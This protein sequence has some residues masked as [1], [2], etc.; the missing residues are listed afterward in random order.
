MEAASRVVY[1]FCLLLVW[2]KSLI[3][4]RKILDKMNKWTNGVRTVDRAL[5][6]RVLQLNFLGS[7]VLY[8]AS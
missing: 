2:V 8:S 4:A 7:H 6:F 5:L 3:H 1:R